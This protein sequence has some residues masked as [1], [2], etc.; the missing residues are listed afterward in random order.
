MI[1]EAERGDISIA[2]V[3]DAMISR[4]MREFREP[5][6]LRLVDVLREADYWA[7]VAGHEAIDAADVDRAIET[8]THRASR[9]RDRVLEA[10]DRGTILIATAGT[11]VGQVNGL[12]VIEASP[13]SKAATEV[14]EL[15]SEVLDLLQR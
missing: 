12:S 3:G 8:Q 11:A 5:A 13:K 9:P 1:Y 2:V 7:G 6:F 10:I 14:R 4:R 15:V